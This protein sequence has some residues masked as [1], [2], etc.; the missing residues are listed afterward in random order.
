M[1]QDP[2]R[3][4]IICEYAHTMGNSLGNF[5]KY[6]DLFYKYPRLQ[7]GFNWDWVDQA[8]RSKDEN[9]REYW[10][11]VNYIDGANANDG[12]INP[13]RTPQPEIHEFKKIIQNIR[14]KDISEGNGDLR[15]YNLFF[16]STLEDVEMDWNLI[17]DG[18]MVQSGVI[19][20][21]KCRS[22]GFY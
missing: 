7:G 8:L 9:G 2:T 5:K 6:W 3:P 21:L 18:L 17:R 16:F 1:N 20:Q 13:D 15:I 19:D 12:L 14:V 22:S 11:I 10:N 4:V